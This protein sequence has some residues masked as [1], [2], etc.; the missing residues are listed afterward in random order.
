MIRRNTKMENSIHTNFQT[1]SLSPIEIERIRKLYKIVNVNPDYT[2]TRSGWPIGIFIAMLNKI[3]DQEKML[4]E[5]KQQM[6]EESNTFS[7]EID[8]IKRHLHL[9]I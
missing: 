2:A 7:N 4:C 3:G 6:I 8:E 5:M 1:K 9:G